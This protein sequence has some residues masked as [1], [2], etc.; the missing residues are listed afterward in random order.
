MRWLILFLLLPGLLLAE[1]EKP[2]HVSANVYFSPHGG[3]TE[4]VVKELAKA[5]HTVL[6]QAYSFTSAPIAAALVDAHKRGVD[7]QVILD[8]TQAKEG[9]SSA[10]FLAN[11]DIPV[12]IDAKP[13]IAHSKVM[14]IDSMTV[15]TGSFNFT[16]SAE[17]DNVE[18]LVVMRGKNFASQ[19][20]ANWHE[21]EKVSKPLQVL[22]NGLAG[23]VQGF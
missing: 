20:T 16:K 21:R 9:Y 19:Y 2:T 1:D 17:N 5:R 13:K 3:C 6:V 11:A 22:S 14:I 10:R 8:K 15:V 23:E 18:N 4:A 7:V 12:L